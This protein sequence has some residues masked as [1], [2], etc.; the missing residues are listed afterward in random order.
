[1]AQ[2]G[3]RHQRGIFDAHLVVLLVALAQA[4]QD[5]DRIFDR[6]LPDVDRL[7]AAF[8]RRI[9]FDV[10]AVLVQRRRPDGV[11]LAAREH[12]LE[13]VRGVH[14]ALGCA[15]ADDRV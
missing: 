15:R 6:W 8:E 9:L 13:H 11:Q 1:M 4:A 3:C 2:H 5:R 14:R 12:G 10:L 7:E